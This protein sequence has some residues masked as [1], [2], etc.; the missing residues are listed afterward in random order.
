MSGEMSKQQEAVELL[1]QMFERAGVRMTGDAYKIIEDAVSVII[2]ESVAYAV[3]AV[4]K[5]QGR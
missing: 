1:A 4:R 2:A 3:D 5:G